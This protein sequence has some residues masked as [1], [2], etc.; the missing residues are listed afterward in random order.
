MNKLSTKNQW[1]KQNRLV[2]ERT[3]DFLVCFKLRTV[4]LRKYELR[5]Y[6]CGFEI[7]LRTLWTIECKIQHKHWIRRHTNQAS[8]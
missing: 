5:R 1:N 6:I 7:N 2:Y 4:K 3:G 8:H